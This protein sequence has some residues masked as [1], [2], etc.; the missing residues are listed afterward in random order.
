MK[1]TINPFKRIKQLEAK[2]AKLETQIAKIEKY[3]EDT[4]RKVVKC[5]VKAEGLERK[6]KIIT[7]EFGIIDFEAFVKIM[8]QKT[9]CTET[10]IRQLR[11]DLDRLK[12]GCDD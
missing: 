7:A 3:A 12:Y 9:N 5:Q 6:A 8:T 1:K 4:G 2:I 10:Q 11:L